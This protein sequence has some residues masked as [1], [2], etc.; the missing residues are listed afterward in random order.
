MARPRIRSR[1]PEKFAVGE[2]VSFT[3]TFS[4]GDMSLFIG[5]T[6]DLNPYHTDDTFA[7]ETRF[8]GASCRGC[9]RPAWRRTWAACGDS[10][11]RR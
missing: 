6:W 7:A 2:R 4:E 3:R 5:A 8:N 10:W 11:P 9:C 1:I